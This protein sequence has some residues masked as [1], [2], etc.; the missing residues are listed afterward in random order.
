MSEGDWRR[1]VLRELDAGVGLALAGRDK[2]VGVAL[3]VPLP[4]G[5]MPGNYVVLVRR[6]PRVTDV[7]AAAGGLLEARTAGAWP[8]HVYQE[9]GALV[10]TVEPPVLVEVAGETERLLGVRVELPVWWIDV[11]PAGGLGHA[12]L[13]AQ[14]VAGNLVEQLG[15]VVWSEP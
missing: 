1:T 5:E 14:R 10:L 11:R 12:S 7:A 6:E 15:G 2:S 4:L 8:I 3:P 13:I 9:G